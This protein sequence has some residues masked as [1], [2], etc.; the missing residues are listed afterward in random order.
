MAVMS[1]STMLRDYPNGE[2]WESRYWS[3]NSARNIN[4]GDQYRDTRPRYCERFPELIRR[5]DWL[6][7]TFS[8]VELS[9]R[10]LE[11]KGHVLNCMNSNWGQFL[12]EWDQ[13]G[14]FR[15]D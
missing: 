1:N 14:V 15:K 9:G 2:F 6:K 12:P 10:A 4:F 13:C 5:R 3:I 7:A 11:A 8:E